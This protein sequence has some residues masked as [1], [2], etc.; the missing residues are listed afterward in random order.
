MVIYKQTKGAF[1]H[2]QVRSGQGR[3]IQL[4]FASR[5]HS[6][7]V[8][9]PTFPFCSWNCKIELPSTLMVI[10][11]QT[12]CKRKRNLRKRYPFHRPA[13]RLFVSD[14]VHQFWISSVN[15]FG[16]HS[17]QFSSS[18]NLILVHI[19]VVH[20][21]EYVNQWAWSHVPCSDFCLWS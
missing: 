14:N 10:Y 20:P 7:T 5:I 19:S 6:F 8:S 13:L 21:S 1:Q 9:E 12:F 2:W 3:D 17:S 4:R 15:E 11:K 18:Q 16:D